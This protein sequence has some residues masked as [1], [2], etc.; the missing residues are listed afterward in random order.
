MKSF[1]HWSNYESRQ[2]KEERERKERERREEERHQ[3]LLQAT[4]NAGLSPW[5]I[6]LILIVAG[7]A[8]FHGFLDPVIGIALA[9]IIGG[10]GM[11][12][13]FSFDG[14][15]KDIAIFVGVIAALG[16]ILLVIANNQWVLI[17]VAGVALFLYLARKGT[18]LRR[19]IIQFNE[20]IERRRL[21]KRII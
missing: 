14:N 18:W 2:E 19:K 12:L 6:P 16:I 10:A 9:V 5:L 13:Y 8:S 7:P 17:P 21:G 1:D 3:E 15:I 11:L 20:W 4:K